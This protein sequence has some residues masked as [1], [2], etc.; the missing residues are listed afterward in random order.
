MKWPPL[1]WNRLALQTKPLQERPA[2]GPKEQCQKRVAIFQVILEAQGVAFDQENSNATTII[3][4]LGRG[5][6]SYDQA[7]KELEQY[8][9]KPENK[10]IA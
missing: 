6:L 10:T 8:A 3:Y 9:I 1:D 4:K 2:I 5:R 7:Y